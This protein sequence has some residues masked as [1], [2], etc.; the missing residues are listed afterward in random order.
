MPRSPKEIIYSEKYC[1]DEF[2]YR[3]VIL[4]E[5]IYKT[6]EKIQNSQRLHTEKEWRS[7]GVKGSPGWVHY[8]YYKPEPHILMLRKK[9]IDLISLF[10]NKYIYLILCNQLSL[11]LQR[12]H[13]KSH[14]KKQVDRHYVK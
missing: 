5:E 14:F 9:R 10:L 13:R 1:D 11:F 7:L 8:D 4:P 2:E 6:L 12:H 3:H